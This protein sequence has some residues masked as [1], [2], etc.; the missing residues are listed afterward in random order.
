MNLASLLSAIENLEQGRRHIVAVA[1]APGSGK[2]TFAE[3]LEA[4]LNR[5][6]PDRARILP[7]DGFHID[8]AVL[9]ERG[10]RPF[11]GA[12]DTFDVDGLASTLTRLKENS[13][14]E[15]AV[16]VF[17]RDLEVARA[18][19]RIVPR[20]INTVIVE[21]NYL[22]VKE[23]PW[24]SLRQYFDLTAYIDIPENV[25]RERLQRRWENYDLS[26]EEIAAKVESNDIPNG[27]YVAEYGSV[28]E[29]VISDTGWSRTF[30]P[31]VNE[32]SARDAK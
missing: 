8:D 26:P 15:V 11:K 3:K 24:N 5:H 1:G 20:Q 25:L 17:D 13:A 18:A 30:A 21:G 32:G 10:R 23:D 19:A 6:H 29:Y 7:M 4:F 22:L 31:A 14:R 27:R 9:K 16:P 2:S 12:P 28:A